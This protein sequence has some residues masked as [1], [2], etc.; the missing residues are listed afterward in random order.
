MDT[1][2]SSGAF[3]AKRSEAALALVATANDNRPWKKRIDDVVTQFF[4]ETKVSG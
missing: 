2:F 3:L 4:G 1:L